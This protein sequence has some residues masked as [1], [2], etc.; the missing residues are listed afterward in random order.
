MKK[1][2]KL[3]NGPTIYT[4]GVSIRLGIFMTFILSLFSMGLQAQDAQW[5]GP[6]RNGI[7]PDQG[8]LKEWPEG[9]PEL[10]L[11]KEGLGKGFSTPVMHGEMIY[12]SGLREDMDVLTKL[13]LNGEIQWETAYGERWE[14]SFSDTRCTPTIEGDRIYI[15]S[16]MGTVVCMDTGTGSIIWEKN[17]HDMFEGEF[18]RWGMVESQLVTEN[19][20]ISSPIG[21]RSAVVA[22]DKNDG[23][24]IWQTEPVSGDGARSYT[25]PLLIT[26][27]GRELILVVSSAEM[28]AVE[29][30][31][32]KLA[33]TYD[34]VTGFTG[35]DDRIMTNTPLFDNGEIFITNGYNDEAA[36]FSLPPDAG[37][38]SL[39]YKNDVLDTHIGGVVLVDGYIYGS[40]WINN[41][42]GNWVCLDWE[43]GEVMY[44]EEWNNKGSIIFADGLLYIYEEKRGHVGLVEPTPEGFRV[45]SSF[46]IED[47]SG[48]YWAHP[49]IYDRKLLLRHGE[50]LFVYDISA[51]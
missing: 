4:V 7:Y 47:G 11:K 42:N 29:P 22:L 14:A 36:M 33:W 45:I 10:I 18:H 16:G 24:V 20:V 27:Q 12:I 15:T 49:S 51:G 19:A 39:K 26:H 40:N 3:L 9:G 46:R 17:T 21:S 43:S 37:K 13:D 5:R 6:Q 44:E 8:L 28:I 2:K 38:P 34:L 50:V 31:T 32:G 25:S 30:E 35:R 48:P 41:G 23:S 1:K